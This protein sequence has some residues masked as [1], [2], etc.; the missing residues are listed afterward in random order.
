MRLPL[1][2]LVVVLAVV[3]VSGQEQGRR[4]EA[5]ARFR[6]LAD[7]ARNG[8][9]SAKQIL[10]SRRRSR[11]RQRVQIESTPLP[12]EPQIESTE[13]APT[14]QPLSPRVKL[15]I[16]RTK[17]R[18]A[19]PVAP[20]EP[21]TFHPLSP[22]ITPT[23]S[24][25]RVTP[26]PE[27]IFV[28]KPATES[29]VFDHFP[30][31]PPTEAPIFNNVIEQTQAPTR[32]R[33]RI[34]NQRLT[35]VL[36]RPQQVSTFEEPLQSLSGF[37]QH[38]KSISGFEE[39]K[40]S[41]A[42]S[43]QPQQSISVF[44]Q[45]QQSIS[46][47]KQPQRSRPAFK[48]LQ[49]STSNFEFEPHRA[50]TTGLEVDSRS[51]P[52]ISRATENRTVRPYVETISRYSYYDEEG[53]YIFGYEA[54]DGSFKEEKRGLDC[55]VTGKYGY[56]DPEGVRREFSYTSG[57]RCDPN[58]VVDPDLGE[59]PALEPNDQF[60]QQTVEQPLTEEE[61]S[62][63]QFSRRRHPVSLQQRQPQQQRPQEPRPQRQRVRQQVQQSFVSDSRRRQPQSPTLSSVPQTIQQVLQQHQD[64]FAP[65]TPAPSS[66]FTTPA[67]FRQFT[68]PSFQVPQTNIAQ[69]Q[70]AVH[71]VVEPTPRPQFVDQRP[72][73]TDIQTPSP[74]FF[75]S[76]PTPKPTAFDFDREFRNLFSH[77]GVTKQT[78]PPTHPTHRPTIPSTSTPTQPA[79]SSPSVRSFPV[80]Q[81]PSFPP[82]LPAANRP[83]S[84]DDRS[85]TLGGGG[86][87]QLVF[88]AATGTFKTVPAQQTSHF[89]LSRPI[90]NNPFLTSATA[91][92]VS[93]PVQ[94]PFL[95]SATAAPVPK[96]VHSHFTAATAAPVPKSVHNHFTA[97]TV[98]PVPKPVQNHFTA[99]TVAP[100]HAAPGRPLPLFT[101]SAGFN[102]LPPV[103]TGGLVINKPGR[104]PATDEFDKFFNQFNL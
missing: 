31:E 87:H 19:R 94:N 53:N 3:G 43:N 13:P 78:N 88:D 37:E 55:I 66:R 5:R 16:R 71:Q 81:A 65:V 33:V 50:I 22:V 45:P 6:A 18:V 14:E 67:S 28:N 58:A 34:K 103:P 17:I 38:Q 63:L 46:A 15:P 57:N 40:Q 7:A 61:L 44:N 93:R 29:P 10:Q 48:Q 68:A 84:F 83:F 92:P 91:A 21:T 77:F 74:H 24:P 76:R 30:T 96:P 26:E 59:A 79:T 73:Q 23:L 1:L 54:A 11:P 9:T 12:E 70:Q 101:G 90:Q 69:E 75:A 100:A 27:E 60:L 20:P 89:S 25:V 39:P 62:Q 102:P 47:F 97:A 56:V 98:A 95:T 41:I 80:S 86:A 49:Q 52:I 42:A 51:E 2:V 64:S 32:R 8:D 4:K 35:P 72:T 82:T 104:S 99:A 36:Q 85:T